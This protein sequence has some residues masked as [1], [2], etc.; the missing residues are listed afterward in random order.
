MTTN[1]DTQTAAPPRRRITTVAK[2]TLATGA[3]ALGAMSLTHGMA[4][5]DKRGPNGT[6][7]DSCALDAFNRFKNGTISWD[8]YVYAKEECCLNLGGIY[9]EQTDECYFDG[10]PTVNGPKPRPG[11]TVLRHPGENQVL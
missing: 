4:N 11:A 3:I 7:F 9:N 1:H 6:A 8:I 5:A 10:E 2:V